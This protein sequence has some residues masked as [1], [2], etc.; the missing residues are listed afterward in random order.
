MPILQISLKFSQ[1]CIFIQVS[2]E[3]NGDLHFSAVQLSD[4]DLYTCTISYVVD[5]HSDRDQDNQPHPPDETYNQQLDVVAEPTQ[6]LRF[7]VSKTFL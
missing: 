1:I 5:G 2:T 6:W 4:S 3:R 7:A